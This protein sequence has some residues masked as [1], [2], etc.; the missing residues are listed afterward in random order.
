MVA[1][2]SEREGSGVAEAPASASASAS[3]RVPRVA[4]VAA[5]CLEAAMLEPVLVSSV[6]AMNPGRCPGWSE[7]ALRPRPISVAPLLRPPPRLA[8][9]R[10]RRG[11][12]TARRSRPSLKV[13]ADP[14]SSS[15]TMAVGS[16]RSA[17]GRSREAPRMERRAVERRVRYGTRCS[18]RRIHPSI[19]GI[20]RRGLSSRTRRS[21]QGPSQEAAPRRE[22][23]VPRGTPWPRHHRT[24]RRPP[25]A[26]A[27]VG[28]P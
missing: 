4:S 12:S 17:L 23:N 14:E 21:V 20:A 7:T 6:R 1:S 11:P 5:E 24:L 16:G 8:G 15:R 18:A 2:A 10:R 27:R 3:I 25:V 13:A 19:S 28:R 22:R 26:G 9:S